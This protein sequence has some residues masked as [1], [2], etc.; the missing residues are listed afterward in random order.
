[1]KLIINYHLQDLKERKTAMEVK[2]ASYQK[3][4]GIFYG[5]LLIFV[6]E[7]LTMGFL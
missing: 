7:S 1:M 6:H 4:H 3:L 2:F 5:D